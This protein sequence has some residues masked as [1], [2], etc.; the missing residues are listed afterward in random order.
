[1]IKNPIYQKQAFNIF[2]LPSILLI[3]CMLSIG[4]FS[5]VYADSHEV[6]GEAA[7]EIPM[8]DKPNITG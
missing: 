1:M 3:V 4:G 7:E 8:D 5:T 2:R 6:E